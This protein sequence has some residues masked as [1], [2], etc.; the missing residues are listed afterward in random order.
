MNDMLLLV[1]VVLLFFYIYLHPLFISASSKVFLVFQEC[2]GMHDMRSVRDYEFF[3]FSLSFSLLLS[4]T[5]MQ[6]CPMSTS[7]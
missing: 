2:V 6:L 7:E 5:S 4:T 1:V 3:L